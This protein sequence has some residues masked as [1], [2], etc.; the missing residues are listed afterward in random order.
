[1]IFRN[2]GKC[3]PVHLFQVPIEKTPREDLGHIV[4]QLRREASRAEILILW[5]DC[6]RE[7]ENIA[8]EVFFFDMRFGK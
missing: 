2:W 1:L 7:G 6:D 3:P 8:F 5:L 4:Q